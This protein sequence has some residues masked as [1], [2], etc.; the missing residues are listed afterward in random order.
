M[1]RGAV[2]NREGG[3]LDCAV[4]D[5]THLARMTFKRLRP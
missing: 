3:A 5:R 4:L 2:R 1:V